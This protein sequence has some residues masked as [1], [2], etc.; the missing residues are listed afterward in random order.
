MAVWPGDLGIFLA[1]VQIAAATP[2]TLSWRGFSVLL[3]RS[4]AVPA[5]PAGAEVPQVG[6][7]LATCGG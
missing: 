5:G 2:E 6:E 1:V 4:V 7:Q 3:G